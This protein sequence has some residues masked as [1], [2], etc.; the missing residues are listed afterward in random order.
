STLTPADYPALRLLL[1]MAAAGH[2][3]QLFEVLP[4]GKH[5]ETHLPVP[6]RR[7]LRIA[8]WVSTPPVVSKS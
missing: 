8:E 2:G 3:P 5:Y 4:A 1:D 7:S 6:S